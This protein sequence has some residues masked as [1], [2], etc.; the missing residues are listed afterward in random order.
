MN[1]TP[2]QEQYLTQIIFYVHN[3]MMCYMA[4]IPEQNIVKINIINQEKRKKIHMEMPDWIGCHSY[5]TPA[6]DALGPGPDRRNT[7]EWYWQKL[8][9]K[10]ILWKIQ[11]D[12]III[13]N[14]YSLIRPWHE[15]TDLEKWTILTSEQRNMCSSHTLI[16]DWTKQT[17]TKYDNH[18][19]KFCV[20][21]P[22]LHSRMTTTGDKSVNKDPNLQL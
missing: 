16:S 11:D 22:Q 7:D 14:E 12:W 1:T 18:D 19:L 4:T 6:D 9:Q 5:F 8:K 10:K 3:L 21:A 13:Q 15:T 2:I 20:T 17:R